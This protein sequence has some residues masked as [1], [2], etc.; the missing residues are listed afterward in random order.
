MAC[1]ERGV[2][3]FAGAQNDVE[4]APWNIRSDPN[5]VILSGSEESHATHAGE[6][7][8]GAD[9]AAAGAWL[10]SKEPGTSPSFERSTI[11]RPSRFSR[12]SSAPAPAS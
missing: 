12:A 8:S 4:W 11:L 9:Q 10:I 1:D 7:T 6:Q 3:F 2:R 5:N